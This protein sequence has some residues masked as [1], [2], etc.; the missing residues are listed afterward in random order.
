MNEEI[1][2]YIKDNLKI[3]TSINVN[4]ITIVLKLEDEVISDSCL[5]L[6][7][8]TGQFGY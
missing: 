3:E 6:N 5:Y 1:K 4:K 2:K 7:R 8:L